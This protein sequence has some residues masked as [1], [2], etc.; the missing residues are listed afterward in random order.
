[1]RSSNLWNEA[2][3]IYNG[4]TPWFQATLRKIGPGPYCIDFPV[5]SSVI[6]YGPDLKESE[7]GL[8]L[9]PNVEHWVK[10]DRRG[11]VV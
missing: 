6:C 1:M 11:C 2:P 10:L 3:N 9:A 7:E 8:A 5:Q 4:S